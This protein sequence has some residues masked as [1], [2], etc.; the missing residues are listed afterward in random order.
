MSVLFWVS[1]NFYNRLKNDFIFSL[2]KKWSKLLLLSRKIPSLNISNSIY[3]SLIIFHVTQ[4][5]SSYGLKMWVGGE[6]GSNK[7]VYNNGSH[8]NNQSFWWGEKSM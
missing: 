6:V 2:T 5:K 8:A 3:E 1:W 4:Y 7:I